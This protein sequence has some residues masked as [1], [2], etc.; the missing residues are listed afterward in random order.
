[1]GDKFILQIKVKDNILLNVKNKICLEGIFK[2]PDLNR[3]EGGFNYRRYLNSQNIYGIITAKTNSI[4]L[5]EK[6]KTDFITKI[7]NTIEE[8]FTKLLPKDYAGI[9]NGM[10]NGD[11]KNVSKK[12]LKDFK[13]SGITHL[14]AVSGSNVAYIIIIISLCSN[15]IFGKYLSYYITII[16]IIIF[17][18]IIFLSSKNSC[19]SIISSV[20][21]TFLVLNIS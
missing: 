7:K 12:I 6:N 17:I 5:L 19:K 15:K 10:L 18:F 4:I 11:T 8:S 21:A 9:I 13:N 2:L 3:N 16:S 20:E 1:M 14:L